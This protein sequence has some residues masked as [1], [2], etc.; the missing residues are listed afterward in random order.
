[1]GTI[2][3]PYESLHD[4]KHFE[5]GKECIASG[6]DWQITQPPNDNSPFP[7]IFVKRVGLCVDEQNL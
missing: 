3:L 5:M 4:G 1:V 2:S 6:A 7:R